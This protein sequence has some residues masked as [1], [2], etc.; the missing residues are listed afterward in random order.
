MAADAAPAS[1][2]TP[3]LGTPGL[4]Q[5][6][7]SVHHDGVHDSEPGRGLRAHNSWRRAALGGVDPTAQS[8]VAVFQQEEADAKARTVELGRARNLT[9]SARELIVKRALQTDEQD[10][11]RLLRKIRERMDRSVLSTS[12]KSRR[13]IWNGVG[14]RPRLL[15]IFAQPI[16]VAS[17]CTHPAGWAWTSPLWRSDSRT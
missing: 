7:P 2:G 3:G 9:K 17:L 10:A 11:E 15:T 6:R 4:E 16:I 14:F 12:S 8:R 5:E 13:G 1:L